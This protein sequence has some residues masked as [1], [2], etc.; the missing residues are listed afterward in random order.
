[1]I[2]REDAHRRL[3]AIL[4]AQEEAD[5]ANAPDVRL[6]AEAEARRLWFELQGA[7]VGE[8]MR[9]HIAGSAIWTMRATDEAGRTPA[10][11]YEAL[12]AAPVATARKLAEVSLHTVQMLRRAAAQ[13]ILDNTHLLPPGVATAFA[14]D[15]FALNLDQEPKFLARHGRKGG[16]KTT[17]EEWSVFVSLLFL[18]HYAAGYRDIGVPKAAEH[19]LQPLAGVSYDR[20]R[21]RKQSLDLHDQCEDWRGKG[22]ADR[23]AGRPFDSGLPVERDLTLLRQVVGAG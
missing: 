22:R 23:L 8:S 10:E 15:L 14:E 18:I 5:G 1:M 3:D 6:A 19:I 13:I 16:G 2:D 20:L 9:A 17:I 7:I 4:D 21:M 11:L 12:Q